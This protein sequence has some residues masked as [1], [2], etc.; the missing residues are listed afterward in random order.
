MSRRGLEVL[1]VILSFLIVV[2][3]FAGFDNLPRKV[4]ADISAAV[5]YTHLSENPSY[6]SSPGGSRTG[7]RIPV[8]AGVLCGVAHAAGAGAHTV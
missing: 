3:L 6:P 1:A 2:V 4:R 7:A 8:H 5:S